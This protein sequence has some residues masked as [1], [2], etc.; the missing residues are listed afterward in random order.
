MNAHRGLTSESRRSIHPQEQRFL[1]AEAL[2]AV[3]PGTLEIQTVSWLQRVVL[4]FVEPDFQRALQHVDEL[5]ALVAIRAAAAGAGCDTEQMRLHY[6]PAKGEQFHLYAR[7]WFQDFSIP[8]TYQPAG[9]VTLRKKRQNA[10]LVQ[11]C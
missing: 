7:I 8:R 3:P 6:L 10:G 9:V 2:P 11:T 1:F 4:H 5:F